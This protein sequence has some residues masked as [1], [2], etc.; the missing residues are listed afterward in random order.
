MRIKKIQLKEYKRFKN[1]T[2]DLGDT[3]KR[4]IA[5]VGP[6][7]C[8]KSSVFD[9]MLF[10]INQYT[11]IGQSYYTRDF[12]YHS[13]TKDSSINSSNIFIDFDQ[14]NFDKIYQIRR[15]V[16]HLKTLFSFRSSFRYN[17]N[18]KIHETKAVNDISKNDYGA[19]FASDID[20]R[21]EED[22][23]RLLAK[24]NQYMESNDLRPSEARR[25]IIGLLNASIKNCLDLEITSLGNIAGD[26]GTLYFKKSDSDTPFEFDVLSAGEKEV[27]DIL[28][29]LFLRKEAYNDSIYIIDEP[30]LH[31]NTSIQRQLLTEP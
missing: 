21:I 22:Y 29:D 10:L 9:G 11:S 31:L 7:G 13:L 4:I 28:L 2:I 8:G 24:F 6:N 20:Q 12:H 14:G 27:V 19:K 26:E 18:L 15:K 16:D 25:D 17:G 1:L 30:E 3:P 5:L 23:R